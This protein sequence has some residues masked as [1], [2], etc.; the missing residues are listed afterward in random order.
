MFKDHFSVAARGYSQYRPDYPAELFSWLAQ[1]AP[2]HE[3]AWDC[4]TGNG[5]AALGLVEHFRRVVASDASTAQIANRRQHERVD[6]LVALA[7]ASALRPACCDL[8]S[9]AQSAHWFDFERFYT[10]VRRVA[11]PG[12]VLALWTY[13]LFGID[14]RIDELLARF[15]SDVVGPYWPP[16]RRFVEQHYRTLP[17]PLE[18]IEAPVFELVTDWNLDLV[19]RY[20]GTWSSVSRFKQQRGFDPVAELAPSLARL[21]G[22]PERSRRVGWPVHLR[23][24]RINSRLVSSTSR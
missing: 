21:W 2:A 9:V 18:E 16:E 4:A 22:D 11:R 20:L 5:Q 3:L 7:E 23:A 17:F 19:V 14:E 15:Y 10:E 1:I 8:I 6:Y 12:G 13:S 24:G